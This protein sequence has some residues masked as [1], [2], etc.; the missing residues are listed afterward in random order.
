[1]VEVYANRWGPQGINYADGR[2]VGV[3]S[4]LVRRSPDN[5]L[6]ALYTDRIRS[7]QISNPMLTDATGNLTFFADPGEY[8]C[9]VHGFTFI[10]SIPDNPDEPESGGGGGPTQYVYTQSVPLATW[11]IN[12]DL[13]RKTHCTIF[14]PF[15]VEVETDVQAGSLFQTTV[16]FPSPA[17]GSAVIS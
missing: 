13:G 15:G 14:D 17:T 9:T 12:H 16:I 10:V 1:M 2:S 5:T 11:I 4:V 8:T 7:A 3:A 6:A